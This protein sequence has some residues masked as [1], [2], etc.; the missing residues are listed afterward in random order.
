MDIIAIN[1]QL[2]LYYYISKFGHSIQMTLS[3]FHPL[4]QKSHKFR[5]GVYS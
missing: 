1:F 4:F 5:I 3:V 2:P